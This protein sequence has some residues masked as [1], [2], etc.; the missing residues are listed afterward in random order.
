MKGLHP[1]EVSLPRT[2]AGAEHPLSCILGETKSC[3]INARCGPLDTL[4]TRVLKQEHARKCSKL[5][6]LLFHPISFR[7]S[8]PFWKIR[9]L[10]GILSTSIPTQWKPEIQQESHKERNSHRARGKEDT[11]TP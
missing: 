5:H 8:E 3:P 6:S 4:N 1:P 11:I 2:C 9:P 7:Y 10:F